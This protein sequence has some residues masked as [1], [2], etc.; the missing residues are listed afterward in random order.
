MS[1]WINEEGFEIFLSKEF[2]KGFRGSKDQCEDAFD[3]WIDGMSDKDW[4]KYVQE[5]DIKKER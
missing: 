5:Y 1:R 2:M 4:A 3:Y